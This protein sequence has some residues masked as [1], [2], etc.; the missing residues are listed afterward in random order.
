MTYVKYTRY[1]IL[2]MSSV[3]YGILSF[4]I[5]LE[6]VFD[7]IEQIPIILY[8]ISEDDITTSPFHSVTFQQAIT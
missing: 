2:I 7:L 6:C 1:G 8:F 3:D 4:V 5:F